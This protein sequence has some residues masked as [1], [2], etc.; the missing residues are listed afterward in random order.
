MTRSKMICLFAPLALAAALGAQSAEDLRL[1]VGKSVVI[2]YPSDIRQIS[3]SNPDVID[4]SP[5]TTRELLM[6]A[7]GLGNATMIVWSKD[8][9]RTFYNVTVDMNLDPL[10]R[11]LR[12]SF[13][14]EKIVPVSSRD[15]ITLD[16]Q[17]T[18][19]EVQD[20][21]AVIAA[22]FAKTVVN[23]LQLNAPAPPV[24]KQVLLRV[25][26]AE[27]DRSKELQYGVNLF[28]LAGQTQ[29]GTGTGQFSPLNLTGTSQVQGGTA[30]VGGIQGT[31][32]SSIITISKALSIF[33]FDPKLNL[34]A[35]IQALQS[36]NI[37]QTLAEPNLVTTN[38]K[39][40]SFLVGG[41]FPVPVLQ[42]GANSGAVTV[43]YR[44]FGIRLIFTPLITPNHTI[45]MHLH[46]EVSALDYSNAVVLNGFTI[47][48]LTSRKAETDVELGEG[49]SFV[50]AGLVNNQETEAFQKIPVLSS[51]PI[52]GSLFK[53]K[54][55]KKNRTDLVVLVTPEITEPLGVSDA[56]PDLYMPRD[57]LVRLDAN[58]AAQTQKKSKK[59]N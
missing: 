43:Q 2:D 47:P 26:F 6:H 12:E 31:Q 35:L 32:G 18:S 57:F 45:K 5:V 37:L 56:K 10:K 13:P 50:I 55:E 41:E 7:K 8:G 23:N 20:R 38:G 42:G 30:L 19:K 28:G 39:E 11:A 16:G 4:A 36:E 22:S 24:D 29:A 46:Q 17:V 9:R 25:R 1:T 44:E 49:Q 15:T 53:S 21:A 14:N 27:L 3:T 48:G 40:A 34:G 52:F 59:S 33:A 54:D 51:L 58:T